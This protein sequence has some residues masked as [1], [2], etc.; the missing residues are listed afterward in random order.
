MKVFNILKC[1]GG[2]LDP[3]Y[4]TYWLTPRQL[5]YDLTIGEKRQLIVAQ[6]MEIEPTYS[7][8]VEGELHLID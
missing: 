5:D 2:G 3:T 8:T 1:S 7:L 4:S 6:R